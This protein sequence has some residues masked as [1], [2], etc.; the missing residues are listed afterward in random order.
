MDWDALERLKAAGNV[1]TRTF[2]LS[3]Y[4]SMYTAYLAA[5]IVAKNADPNYD[6][7]MAD[8]TGATKAVHD[9]AY[10]YPVD[11]K[12]AILDPIQTTAAAG[13]SSNTYKVPSYAIE[14]EQ[15]QY[16]ESTAGTDAV[17]ANAA[18]S[19]TGNRSGADGRLDGS[20]GQTGGGT[21]GGTSPGGG[22]DSGGGT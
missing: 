10:S 15:G 6:L 3:G 20:G 5:G 18:V 4:E 21:G 1:L 13:G 9:D 19:D 16:D 22:T 11:W 8:D 7:T 17:F 2:H 14:V 12:A